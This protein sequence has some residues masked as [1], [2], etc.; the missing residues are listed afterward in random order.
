MEFVYKAVIS[1]VII[2]VALGVPVLIEGIKSFVERHR[3]RILQ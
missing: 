3:G 1:E 2:G